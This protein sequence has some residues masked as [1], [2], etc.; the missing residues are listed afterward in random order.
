ME[1]HISPRLP[2][3][4]LFAFSC[5]NRSDQPTCLNRRNTGKTKHERPPGLNIP[6]PAFPCRMK[7]EIDAYENHREVTF[8][9]AEDGETLARSGLLSRSEA[10]EFAG[11]LREVAYKLTRWAEGNSDDP[12]QSVLPFYG[13]IAA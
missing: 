11:D 3:S 6:R 5:K 13:A 9:S 10:L 12:A 7:I 8:L 4:G 1:V 2:I